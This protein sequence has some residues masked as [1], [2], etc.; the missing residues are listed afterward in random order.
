MSSMRPQLWVFAGPNGAGKS[1][2]V[3][4]YRVASRIPIVNPDD[5]ARAIG[6]D[7]PGA[8][9]AQ[10]QA[11][12]LAIAQRKQLLQEGRS[13][14]I[15]TTLTGRRELPFMQTAKELGYK[16]NLVYVGL[17]EVEQS[18]VRVAAR[19]Q[20]G[21]H[22]V[23]EQDLLR[24]FDRS[25]GHLADAIGLSDRVRILDNS[26]KT[27]RL[28]LSMDLGRTKFVT[29]NLPDWARAAVPM[30]MQQPPQGHPGD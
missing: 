4:R 30:A 9:S 24:R 25:L 15:E 3:S 26:G 1:T 23:P 19:V 22:D 7:D 20:R 6:P 27:Y 5:I 18:H 14:G 10:N 28:L 17:S 13:F 8:T 2:L 16:L 12:R 11:G 21:G 29:R